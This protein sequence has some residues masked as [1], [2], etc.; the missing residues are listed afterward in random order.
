MLDRRDEGTDRGVTEQV[1]RTREGGAAAEAAGRSVVREG[2]RAEASLAE[3]L[4]TE[5][6]GGR[7][8]RV[9]HEFFRQ[10]LTYA[11]LYV[12]PALTPEAAKVCRTSLP[13]VVDIV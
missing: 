6:E 1:M 8:M 2:G 13:S 10:Y 3:R 7:A 5:E 9:S 11:R 4:A 12:R